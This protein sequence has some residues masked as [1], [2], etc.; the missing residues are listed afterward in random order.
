MSSKTSTHYFSG[1]AQWAK[2]Y[3][4]DDKYN[5]FSIDVA[6]NPTA[7]KEYEKLGLH[8]PKNGFKQDEEGNTWVTFRRN[9]EDTTYRDGN[10]VPCG[11][12]TVVDGNGNPMDATIGNGSDVTVKV[13]VYA[14]NN[15]FGKGNGSRLESVRVDNLV[16]YQ[17]PQEGGIN[18]PF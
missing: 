13:M 7:F 15:K 4:P 10:K 17:K 5:K 16:E 18:H 9:P 2:V 12:P 8:K 14:Y 3:R 1:K 6:L 11:A